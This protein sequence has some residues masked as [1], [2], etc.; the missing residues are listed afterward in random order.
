MNQ[1]R[2]I[3]ASGS[4]RRK[5]LLA[6][7]GYDFEVFTSGVDEDAIDISGLSPQQ[8]AVKLALAKAEAVAKK[9]PNILVLGCDTVVDL[10]GQIIGKAQNGAHALRIITDLFSR[11]HK[12]ITGAAFVHLEKGIEKTLSDSTTVYPRKL[13]EAQVE[14]HIESGAWKGK[15]GAYGLQEVNDEFVERIEGSFTNVVGLP[16]EL[17]EQQLAELGCNK[18]SS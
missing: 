4:P 1:N 16:M 2:F 5:Q 13:T 18:P 9:H 11:P 14:A 3:L 12:V 8:A 17:L 6:E 15:A 7:A 10:D